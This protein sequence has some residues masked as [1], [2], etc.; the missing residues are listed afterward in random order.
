MNQQFKEEIAQRICRLRLEAPAVFWLE[1]YKPL[2]GLTHS[3][4]LVAEPVLRTLA[5]SEKIEKL[6]EFL[7]ERANIEELISC[8]EAKARE[9]RE[10]A[11]SG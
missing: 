4:A 5:G 1:M 10:A 11:F 7:Q 3:A 6:L 8:I 2:I 9:R